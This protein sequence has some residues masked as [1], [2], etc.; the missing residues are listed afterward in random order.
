LGYDNGKAAR[1]PYQSCKNAERLPVF[2]VFFILLPVSADRYCKISVILALF[3]YR[4][5][6]VSID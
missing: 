6:E 2:V 4:Y 1:M 3:L 5:K